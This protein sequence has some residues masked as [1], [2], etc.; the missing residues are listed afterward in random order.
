[1]NVRLLRT[2]VVL[3]AYDRLRGFRDCASSW[4][5]VGLGRAYASAWNRAGRNPLSV[6][7]AVE[8]RLNIKLKDGII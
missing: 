7:A 3:G 6:R 2:A 4:N 1:M 5:S 8:R